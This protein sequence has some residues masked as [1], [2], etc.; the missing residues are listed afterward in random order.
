MLLPAGLVR[1]EEAVGFPGVS[2]LAR[3][4]ARRAGAGKGA[5]LRHG[6]PAALGAE[7]ARASPLLPLPSRPPPP[8]PAR[9]TRPARPPHPPFPGTPGA[10]PRSR[11]PPWRGPVVAW[12]PVGMSK[13]TG[14]SVPGSWG[15]GRRNEG[16]GV[17][18]SD[19][20]AGFARPRVW[21]P[22][23]RFVPDRVLTRAE[24]SPAAAA[25][26]ESSP[27]GGGGGGAPW[28][29]TCLAAPMGTDDW[30]LQ[31]AQGYDRPRAGE[32]AR[33]GRGRG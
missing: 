21:E 17:G 16:G 25:Q 1:R 18:G 14:S 31:G 20:A 3:G 32:R 23:A 8:P 19:G 29:D 33:R 2:F 22:R 15:G 4:L 26:S 11:P 24:L 6:Q 10:P 9:R 13:P 7:R 5:R 30:A 12:M 27:G 28:G